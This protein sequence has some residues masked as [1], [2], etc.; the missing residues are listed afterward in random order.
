MFSAW[1][2][3]YRAALMKLGAWDA[4]KREALHR[5]VDLGRRKA[6]MPGVEKIRKGT[7]TISQEIPLHRT[8]PITGGPIANPH[9]NIFENLAT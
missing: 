2:Q 7:S 1:E 8:H 4:T 3:G 6:V 9:R 5:V